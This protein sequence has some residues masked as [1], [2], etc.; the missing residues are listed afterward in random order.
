[1]T[2]FDLHLASEEP[3]RY[4]NRPVLAAAHFYRNT[5]R[6]ILTHLFGHSWYQRGQIAGLVRAIGGEPPVTDFVFWVR[7]EVS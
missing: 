6:D 4:G 7:E 5:V 1:L 2:T 3:A